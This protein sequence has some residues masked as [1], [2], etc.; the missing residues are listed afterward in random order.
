MRTRSEGTYPR[1]IHFEIAWRE[2]G[3]VYSLA[4]LSREPTARTASSTSFE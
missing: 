2:I 1:L 4:T 3:G